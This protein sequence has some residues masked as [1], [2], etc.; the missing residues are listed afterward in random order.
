[1][2]ADI[3]SE[4]WPASCRNTWPAS[5]GIRTSGIPMGMQIAGHAFG[6][7]TLLRVAYAFEQAIGWGEMR[8]PLFNNQSIAAA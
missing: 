3:K 4:R 5:I 7:A 8:P 6:E 2:V 1:M